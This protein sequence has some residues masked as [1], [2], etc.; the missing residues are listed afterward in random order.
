LIGFDKNDQSCKIP[1]IYKSRQGCWRGGEAQEA[2]RA[3][4]GRGRDGDGAV[5]SEEPR[6]AR[7]P[8]PQPACPLSSMLSLHS[9]LPVPLSSMLSLHSLLVVRS[10]H[11]VL[12]RGPPDRQIPS[13]PVLYPLCSPCTPYWLLEVYILY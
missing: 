7:P 12:S 8:D 9:L 3:G 6:P 13:L 11:T 5:R 2:D 1:C 10:I 4:Q